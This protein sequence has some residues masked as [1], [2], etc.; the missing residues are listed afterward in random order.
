MHLERTIAKKVPAKALRAFI[1]TEVDEGRVEVST[2]KT[3]TSRSEA[4]ATPAG[5]KNARLAMRMPM[6]A[7]IRTNMT[8][9]IKRHAGG[10]GGKIPHL[11]AA[12][13][14]T[15]IVNQ[16]QRGGTAPLAE[17]ALVTLAAEKEVTV[18]WRRQARGG[19]TGKKEKD[20]ET[21]VA[22]TLRAEQWGSEA[23]IQAVMKRGMKKI[24]DAPQHTPTIL[25]L[26]E[27][28]H[29]AGE[30]MSRAA[31]VI[32]VDR[33][34]QHL[35]ATVKTTP[36]VHMEIGQGEKSLINAIKKKAGIREGELI[37][38]HASPDCA[39]ES[40]LQRM[41]A[42]NQRGKGAHA[43]K[44]RP[45]EQEAAIKA[46]VSGI[47]QALEDDP[48]L[49]YTVENPKDSA[50]TGRR[51]LESLPGEKRVVKHCCYGTG[52][53]KQTA[54]WTNLG[55]WWHPKCEQGPHWLQK[56]PHC[57]ACNTNTKH[58]M[59]IIRRGKDDDRKPATIPGMNQAAAKNRVP[60]DMAEEWARAA[61]A[62]RLS[63]TGTSEPNG[64]EGGT[65]RKR[66][67]AETGTGIVAAAPKRKKTKTNEENPLQQTSGAAR[68]RKG[69]GESAKSKPRRTK[70]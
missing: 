28:W 62:R 70:L 25:D 8:K 3:T 5:R 19:A 16:S 30:G 68:G 33:T 69:N 40:I 26:G 60:P 12:M 10:G 18:T 66:G 13:A 49:S 27:G 17:A 9:W 34:R 7:R 38:I 45:G 41:E 24:K 54:V 39:P 6:L 56:C 53:Q 47:Q 23:E 58:E 67:R 61:I 11:T 31:R 37:H 52:W 21:Q 43:G 63:M 51:D 46:I 22:N 50:L 55:T 44:K 1:A 29:G 59:F 4:V 32:G 64:N 35:S 14:N 36:D 20:L 42:A 65:V 48:Y 2:Q 15:L 57:I